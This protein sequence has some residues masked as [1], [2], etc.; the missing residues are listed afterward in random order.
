MNQGSGR[1]VPALLVAHGDLASELKATAETIAG[2][3]DDLV[4]LSNCDC[5]PEELIAEVTRRLDAIGP[6]PLVLVDLAGGSCLAA[7]QRA[8]RLRPDVAVVAGV[9]LPLLLDYLQKRDTLP[10]DELLAHLVDRGR[11]G[12]KVVTGGS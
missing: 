12:L 8:C 3:A 4:C 7:V 5:S 1:R 2:P 6:G 10:R 11:A 9:N